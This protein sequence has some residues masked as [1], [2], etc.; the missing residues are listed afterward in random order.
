METRSEGKPP[1]GWY[2][3]MVAETRARRARLLKRRRAGAT[4]Q[5]LADAEGVS[6]QRI[7]A[8]LRQAERDELTPPMF[9]VE[10]K[11]GR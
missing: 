2:R 6:H 10:Q 7:S 9:H 5:E 8:L 4:L 11:A 3:Q 1:A